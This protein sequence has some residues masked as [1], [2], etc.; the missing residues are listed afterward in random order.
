MSVRTLP[1]HITPIDPVSD[2]ADTARAARVDWTRIREA[3][4]RPLPGI[5]RQQ[6]IGALVAARHP[7]ADRDLQTVLA[8][9]AEPAPLR[10]LAALSLIRLDSSQAETVLIQALG[11]PDERVLAAVTRALGRIGSERGLRAIEAL[12]GLRGVA[13]RQAG[14]AQ[15]LIA[16]RLGLD[17]HELPVPRDE[18]LLHLPDAAARPFRTQRLS[19]ADADHVLRTLSRE[20]FG[21]E[22][23]ESTLHEIRCASTRWV[24]AFNREV[25]GADGLERLVNRKTLAGV[26]ASYQ[27]ENDTYSAR[28]LMLTA[29]ERGGRIRIHLRRLLGEPGLFGRVLIKASADRHP[30]SIRA[31]AT[32]GMFPVTG[33]GFYIAGGRIEFTTARAGLFIHASRRPQPGNVPSKGGEEPKKPPSGR[34]AAPKAAVKRARPPKKAARTRKRSR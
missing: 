30:F 5:T 12:T 22:Y 7:G 16:H 26:L 23:D 28:L 24:V 21:I 27:D 33:E 34:A 6:A 32:P 1:P 31:V 29:P 10:A 13:A 14:F 15:S 8:N 20:P 17:G 3:V 9:P 4:R 11:D 25:T 18:D 2:P 19:G